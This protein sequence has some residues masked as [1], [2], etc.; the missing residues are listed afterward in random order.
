M[1]ILV[2]VMLLESL[3]SVGAIIICAFWLSFSILLLLIDLGIDLA[4][5][6]CEM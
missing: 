4:I 1:C 5:M 3:M 6:L 2:M